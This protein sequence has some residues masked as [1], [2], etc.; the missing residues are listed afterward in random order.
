[1]SDLGLAAHKIPNLT[2]AKP[3]PRIG[4][5]QARLEWR[6]LSVAELA[7][8]FGLLANGRKSTRLPLPVSLKS[9]PFE[10]SSWG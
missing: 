4:H 9:A 7:K 2:P 8:S 5:L 6:G 3:S 10:T 1:M